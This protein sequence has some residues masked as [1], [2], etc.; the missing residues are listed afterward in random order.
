MEIILYKNTIN[1][2]ERLLMIINVLILIKIKNKF[3]KLVYKLMSYPA[4][5]K[6]TKW[7]QFLTPPATTL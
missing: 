2:V 3:F 6:V 7:L 4:A 1:F 5:E